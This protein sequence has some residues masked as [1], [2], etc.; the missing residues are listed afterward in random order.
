ML[1]KLRSLYAIERLR[2]AGFAIILAALFSAAT[3]FRPIDIGIWSMQSKMFD[4]QP[5]GEIALVTL[6]SSDASTGAVVASRQL[7]DTLNKLEADGA[8]RVVLD[9]PIRKSGAD[10]LDS[11]LRETLLG[12]GDRAVLTRTVRTDLLESRAVAETDPY[13]TRDMRVVSSDYETDFLDFV[14]GVDPYYAHRQSKLPA[15]WTVLAD[16]GDQKRPVQPDYTV[17]TAAVPHGTST[18]LMNGSTI[19]VAGK[20]VVLGATGSPARSVKVPNEGFVTSSLVHIVGAETAKRGSGQF[21]DW[22]ISIAGFGI[23]FF[24]LLAT[25]RTRR[26]RRI[27]YA[28]WML[29]IG[30]AIVVASGLGIRIIFT[31]PLGIAGLFAILRFAANFKRRHLQIEQRSGLPNFVAMNRDLGNRIGG[32]RIAIVAVKIAR[33]DAIFATLSQGDQ[34]RYLRQIA[35]RLSLG[36]QSQTIYYDGGKN[37]AFVLPIAAYNDL[38][39]HLEGLR[40]I[41]SQSVSL[42]QRDLDVSMTVGVDQSFEKPMASRLNSAI[43]AADQAREAYRP[44]FV[45]SDFEAD[46]EEW[47]YSLQ[48]RLEDAL[49]ED[50]I[51][52]KLQPQANLQTGEIIGAE[53]LARWVDEK[54][55]DVSP[56]RFILQ[57]ERAGRLDDLTKRITHKTLRAAESLLEDGFEPQ[58]SINVSAIQFVDHRIADLVEENLAACRMNPANLVIEVTETARIEDFAVAREVFERIGKSGVR[59]SIDDFGIASANFDALSELPFDEIKID[60]AFVHRMRTSQMARS[61]VSNVIRLAGET[62]LVSVAEGIEDR[63]S[64]EMLKDLGCDIG[65]GFYIAR[66]LTLGELSETL[67]LQRDRGRIMRR[68]G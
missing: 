48:A 38:Q 39:G 46:S 56:A 62:G 65:Q 54:H 60:L 43:A 23:A 1:Q 16:E 4:K 12:L 50:R 47:D 61:I 15:M 58:I 21:Y 5:S 45:I 51:G 67:G 44:V 11:E 24:L 59:F 34:G 31:G 68:I 52:I 37:L 3:I 13:F 63:E 2:H 29:A 35:G 20:T 41:A 55:G 14:W 42:S 57:C 10:K 32:E 49:S 33:L 26:R 30:F 18:A 66:P 6:E 7:V 25:L 28:L 40:A 17:Q 53:S 8:K 36:E 9:F 22:G 27:G 19:E 64:Y